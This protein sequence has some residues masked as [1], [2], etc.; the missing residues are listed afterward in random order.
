MISGRVRWVC[1]NTWGLEGEG[2]KEGGERTGKQRESENQGEKVL[3]IKPIKKGSRALRS[4][5]FMLTGR[6]QNRDLGWRFPVWVEAKLDDIQAHFK[7]NTLKSF[8]LGKIHS[9]RKC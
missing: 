4:S 5:E 3:I 6:I 8:D 2:C 7:I 1:S 9:A